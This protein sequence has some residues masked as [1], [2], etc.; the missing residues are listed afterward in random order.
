[1]N[2]RLPWLADDDH[3]PRAWP[4]G[5]GAT[6]AAAPAR[7]V[8][9]LPLER[10]FR[11]HDDWQAGLGRLVLPLD[12]SIA[13]PQSFQCSAMVRRLLRNTVAEL[14]V[15]ASRLARRN[16][17]IDAGDADVVE[18]VWL[19]AGRSRTRQGPNSAT[20]EAGQWTVLDPGR[21]YALEFDHGSR[22]LLLLVPRAA[23]PSWL[24]ALNVLAG[25]AL[26]RGGPAHIAMASLG[27]MLR[28]VV[29]LD[30]KSEAALH[31]SIIALIER[32]L[33]IELGVLG[34]QGLPG[35]S[36]PLP[37]VQR[38]VLDHLADTRM[39]VATLAA[40]FGISRRNLYNIFRASGSTPREFIQ[41]A[42]LD[43]ACELLHEPE[44]RRLTVASVARQCGFSDPAHFSRAFR[45][46]HGVAP[47]TWRANPR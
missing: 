36:I 27:A 42:R 33:W 18:V 25:R 26:P 23:C 31:E 45:A 44:G 15:E 35:R 20:L 4:V 47:T 3:A 6:V 29:P 19:L 9:T 17:H 2:D 5:P 7:A 21:E 28:D 16:S 46:R 12:C 22:L 40:V 1:M 34:L 13:E 11:R 37:Q 24:P 39:N 32:A 38:Y 43:R 41:R 30:A 8:A 14:R 10:V